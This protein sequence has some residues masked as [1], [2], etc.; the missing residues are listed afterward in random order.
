[1]CLQT[2]ARA[3]RLPISS[4][5][6]F[7]TKPFFAQASCKAVLPMQAGS[8]FSQRDVAMGKRGMADTVSVTFFEKYTAPDGVKIDAP[9]GASL[10]EVAQ[11]NDLEL[12]GA[13]EGTL[14]CSTCHCI[15]EKD[16]FDSLP[17]PDEEE[18]DMLDLAAGLTDTSRLGCQVKLTKEFE[19]A[20][21]HIPDEFNNMQ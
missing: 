8:A 6:S 18:L 2:A 4:A 10:L 11:S 21:I 14:A 12:E 7:T 1:M 20:V 5:R 13:C 17:P 15:L 16:V 3:L 9:L 19:G